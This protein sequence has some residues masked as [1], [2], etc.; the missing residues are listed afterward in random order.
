MASN[1]SERVIENFTVHQVI[2]GAF[3]DEQSE[4]RENKCFPPEY[5]EEESSA[6]EES[7]AEQ[8]QPIKVNLLL[9]LLVSRI[10]T[11]PVVLPNGVATMLL[12]HSLLSILLNVLEGQTNFLVKILIHCKLKLSCQN[13]FS[14]GQSIFFF[15]FF[16]IFAISETVYLSL[17]FSIF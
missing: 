4:Y 11:I 8:I 16:L 7:N 5:S 15:F 2:E 3:V 10:L 14:S 6:D 1:L 17:S 9:V 13:G 12:L